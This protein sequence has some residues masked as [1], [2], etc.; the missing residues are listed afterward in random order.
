MQLLL[1]GADVAQQFIGGG[2]ALR[3]GRGVPLLRMADR[4]LEPP[5]A[6]LEGLVAADAVPDGFATAD[7][8]REESLKD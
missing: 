6:L 5:H 8:L 2:V 3:R 7:A 1:Q 4:A